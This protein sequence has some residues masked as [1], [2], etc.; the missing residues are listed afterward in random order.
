[1]MVLFVGGPWDRRFV[2]IPEGKSTILTPTGDGEFAYQIYT[3][4]DVDGTL[5]QIAC[6][7]GQTNP[8]GHL[9]ATYASH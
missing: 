5:R 4:Q 9:M 8:I 1:M 3:F 7:P 6:A 2:A